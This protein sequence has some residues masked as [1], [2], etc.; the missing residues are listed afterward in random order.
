M[1][2][3]KL[4]NVGLVATSIS[5]GDLFLISANTSNT[6]TT[7]VVNSSILFGNSSALISANQFQMREKTTPANSTVTMTQGR[8]FF[9]EDYLYI[10]VANNTLKRVALSSF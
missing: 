2:E 6:A 3:V 1:A 8:I 7:K 4:S 10:A 5:N 9:D